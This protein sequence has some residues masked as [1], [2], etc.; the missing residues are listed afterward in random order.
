[1]KVK[2]RLLLLL[3]KDYFFNAIENI[4][5]RKQNYMQASLASNES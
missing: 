2:K 1:M 3:K 4:Q 5:L